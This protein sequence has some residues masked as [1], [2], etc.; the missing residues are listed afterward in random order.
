M[1]FAKDLV[2][3]A[4]SNL[5]YR[6]IQ[7]AYAHGDVLRLARMLARTKPGTPRF[8]ALQSQ[9][10]TAKERRNAAKENVENFDG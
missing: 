1:E 8:I 4:L 5:G 10:V 3:H 9:L 7:L 2:R 6:K